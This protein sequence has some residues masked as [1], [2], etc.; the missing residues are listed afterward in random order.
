MSL[1]SAESAD[2]DKGIPCNQVVVR[3]SRNYTQMAG[4][5]ILLGV[6]DAR[7]ALLLGE[8]LNVATAVDAAVAGAYALSQPLIVDSLLIT[9]ADATAEA[10]RLKALKGTF[11][12]WIDPTFFL[13]DSSLALEVGNVIDIISTRYGLGAGGRRVVMSVSPDLAG[14]GLKTSTWG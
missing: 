6:N 3:Y 5:D 2:D 14:G 1:E 12:S 8:W 11:R 4:T 9:A 10:T 7:R 13:D